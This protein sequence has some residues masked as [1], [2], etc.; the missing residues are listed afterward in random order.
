M[1]KFIT[2]HQGAELLG[3]SSQTLRRWEREG[4]GIEVKRT[5]GGQRRYDVSKLPFQKFPVK[6]E[7][8]LTIAY[9]RV[10]C[11]D[12][13]ADL[14]RQEEMLGMFC[15][16][17][18]WQ[19]EIITDL[20]SGMNYHKSGLKNLLDKIL[21]KNMSRLVIT[22]KDRLLR[23]GAELI[24]SL[25]KENEIEVVIINQGDETS[26]EEELAQD[27]IEIITVFSAKLYG[28]RSHKNRQLR[29]SLKKVAED[30]TSN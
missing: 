16:A 22:H 5:I 26:F 24:F 1:S 2:I 4:K 17:K 9:A 13:K 27:V 12:Q 11:Y 21:E 29:E 30:A 7:H 20:G 25:C 3:V 14:L 6:M 8:P 28:A 19:F 23:F 18:G 10:S 15:S